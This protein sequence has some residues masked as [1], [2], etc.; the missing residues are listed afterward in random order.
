MPKLTNVSKVVMA[1]VIVVIFIV[2]VIVYN[3]GSATNPGPTNTTSTSAPGA[4]LTAASPTQTPTSSVAQTNSGQVVAPR[5]PAIIIH[6]ITPVSKDIWKIGTQNVISWNKAGGITGS[7]SLIN[8]TTKAFMGVV[9]PQVGPNQTSYTWNTRD[10]L[11][12]RTNPLKKDVVSGTYM[13]KLSYDG[14]NVQPVT[15]P[16]FTITN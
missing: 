8:A 10:L 13:L 16:V 5:P 14:N 9:L 1:A 11:L 15:S 4:T 7:I 3:T 12:D 6:M 2:L